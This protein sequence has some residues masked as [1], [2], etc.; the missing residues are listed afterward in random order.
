MKR[1]KKENPVVVILISVLLL[2]IIVAVSHLSERFR[3]N[4]K[5]YEGNKD[6]F[7]SVSVDGRM[8]ESYTCNGMVYLFLPSYVTS[9]IMFLDDSVSGLMINGIE[10]NR[11]WNFI[12]DLEYEFCYEL[13]GVL[14]EGK[15]LIKKSSG[16]NTIYINTESG[17]MENVWNDK[18]YSETGGQIYI[19]DENGKAIYMGEL[20]YIKG[21]GNTTWLSSNKKP[22]RI[23]LGSKAALF[24]MQNEDDWVLLANSYDGSKISNMIALEMAKN[25]G[26]STT[27]EVTWVD[28]Y[29]NGDYAGNYLLSEPLDFELIRGNDQDLEKI[30]LQMNDSLTN[31]TQFLGEDYKGIENLKNPEDISGPYLVERDME[32]YY[33]EELCGFVTEDGNCW[34]LKYPKY[35]SKEQVEYIKSYVSSIENMLRN[36]DEQVFEY[37]D[38]ETAVLRYFVDSIT[39]NVDMGIS[40]MYFYKPQNSDKL[41]S[42]PVWDY[43]RCFGLV[44]W[45]TYPAATEVIDYRE[46]E[47]ISWQRYFEENDVFQEYCALKYENVVRPYIIE[48]LTSK[49]DE[50]VAH[51]EKSVMMDQEIWEDNRDYYDSW[52]ANVSYIRYY[53]AERMAYFDEKYGVEGERYTY[54]GNGNKHKVTVIYGD[55][56]TVYYVEDGLLFDIPQELDKNIYEGWYIAAK[57]MPYNNE[58]PILEDVTIEAY[59]LGW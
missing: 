29:L 23:K 59:L 55:E 54:E 41:Y 48:L 49:L 47:M 1:N 36:G 34:S 35:A 20:A 10:V 14:Y 19:Y 52:E 45:Q 38:I 17:S 25:I 57:D 58:I 18:D 24:G 28:L 46:H 31:Y 50:Y 22:Y 42:G 27:P 16:I 6:T 33:E 26:L 32:G 15:L 11:W 9:D 12:Y 51:V 56:E 40:S 53:L 2:V 8:I 3:G 44:G 7:F 5:L 30:T 4:L 39:G 21:R 13:D 43:D 37:L